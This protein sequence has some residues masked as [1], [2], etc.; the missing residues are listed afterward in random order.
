MSRK[1]SNLDGYF[2]IT[3]MLGVSVGQVHGK[4]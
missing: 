1:A 3:G 4:H 2:E